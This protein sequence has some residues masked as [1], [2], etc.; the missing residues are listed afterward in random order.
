MDQ[1]DDDDDD[2][3]S[4][5]FPLLLSFDFLLHNMQKTNMICSC[6]IIDD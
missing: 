2:D 6:Y 5:L 4:S 3:D 1:E